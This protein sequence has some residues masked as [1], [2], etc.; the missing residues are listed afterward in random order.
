MIRWDWT[1]TGVALA[2]LLAATPAQSH[3]PKPISG[4]AAY[5]SSD[6]RGRTASGERYDP[7]KFT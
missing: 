1:A 3:S 2:C 4:I 7:K 6:Y 5:Y